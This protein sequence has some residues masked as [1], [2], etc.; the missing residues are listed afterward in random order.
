[1]ARASKSKNI[2]QKIRQRRR[3][4]LPVRRRRKAVPRRVH[5]E[6]VP[7]LLDVR[8]PRPRAA[9][10]R[11]R[12]QAGAAADRLRDVRAGLSAQ[13][14]VQEVGAHRRRRA[15]QIPSARRHRLL[16]GDGADGAAVQ[17][18]LSAGRRPGEL[19][20]AGRSEVVRRHALHRVAADAVRAEC[21]SPSWGRGRSTGARTSTAPWRSRS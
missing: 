14:Q 9:Q 19:G 16:R 12:P 6:G 3:P 7:R 20:L 1:M 13:R 15:R 4:A 10:R 21:C 2:P 17:P 11:G 18:A 5:R 8:H